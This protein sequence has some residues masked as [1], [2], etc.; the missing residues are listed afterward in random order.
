MIGEPSCH[1][2]VAV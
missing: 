1:K 2:P